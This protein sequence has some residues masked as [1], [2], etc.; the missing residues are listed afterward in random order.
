[1]SQG[2]ARY[3]MYSAVFL[4]LI[5][6]GHILLSR[7]FNT[8]YSDG[9]YSLPAGHLD[10]G[11]AARDAMVREAQEEIG[12]TLTVDDLTFAHVLHRNS[13]DEREYHDYFFSAEIPSQTPQ[14]MEPEKCDDLRWFP[15]NDLPDNLVA[16]VRQ[17]IMAI[18]AG[19]PFGE[20][21]FQLT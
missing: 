5:R 4:V 1:M 11:E 13:A 7:R 3:P 10:G 12:V 20:Y 8:G 14:N 19:Q 2:T 21:G 6:D 15:L 16:P 17:A 18:Q 9:L